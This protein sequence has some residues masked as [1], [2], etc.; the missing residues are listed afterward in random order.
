MEGL[1]IA[2]FLTGFVIILGFLT[3][4]G[5]SVTCY[6]CNSAYDP[7]CGDPFDAF[8]LGEVNCQMRQ[9]PDHLEHNITSTICRKIV[10]K[11]YGKVRVVRGCGYLVDQTL[12]DGRSCV[13][14]SGTHD[15]QI[16]YCACQG[17]HCNGGSRQPLSHLLMFL[18]A[19]TML[20]KVAIIL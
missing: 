12:L 4:R 16:V 10:Q 14:R 9:V 2:A 20:R 3:G 11:T 1:R 5:L 17:D 15:V 8:S 7:R 18:A 13:Q 19:A 6:Q